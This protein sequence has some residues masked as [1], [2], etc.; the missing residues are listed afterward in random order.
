MKQS[1][2][3]PKNKIAIYYQGYCAKC[4]FLSK[5]VVVLSLYIIERIPLEVDE[6]I[7]LFFEDY[8]KAKGYPILF[9]G[10]TPIYNYWVFPAVP[11]A[12]VLSW[13]YKLQSFVY[14]RQLTNV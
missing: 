7:Q 5:L 8:P 1:I 12:I 13:F 11:F 9:L 4:R 2:I 10:Q 3:I 6:S 14:S